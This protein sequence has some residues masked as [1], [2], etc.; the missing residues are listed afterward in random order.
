MIHDLTDRWLLPDLEGRGGCPDRDTMHRIVGP[1]LLSMI[2][3]TFM[4]GEGLELAFEFNRDE[5]FYDEYV[6]VI[7]NLILAA[8]RG[9]P[10]R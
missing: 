5:A 6:D 9:L 1:A 8:L 3:S 4:F 10:Q 7:S 2:Y